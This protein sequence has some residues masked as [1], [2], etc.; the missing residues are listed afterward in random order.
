MEIALRGVAVE[1]NA[2]ACAAH[3]DEPTADPVDRKEHVLCRGVNHGEW[4]GA[5]ATKDGARS[6]DDPHLVAQP[7][8]FE[9]PWALAAG[10]ER[11]VVRERLL[12]KIPIV[13][14]PDESVSA[15]RAA[16]RIEVVRALAPHPVNRLTRE[17]RSAHALERR[18]IETK[19]RRV[20]PGHERASIGERLHPPEYAAL[21]GLELSPAAPVEVKDEW[22]S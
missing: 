16:R 11:Q 4:P 21:S 19:D 20:R 8:G 1:K 12:F 6:S 13:V 14:V 17:S 10:G 18:P 3:G 2:I 7:E 15:A 5:F 22:T 9:E